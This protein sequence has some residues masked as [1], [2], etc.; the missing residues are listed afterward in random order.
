MQVRPFVTDIEVCG[1]AID[2]I[3][4]G[5]ALFPDLGLEKLAA[6]GIGEVHAADQ[7]NARPVVLIDRQRWYSQQ[8]WLDAF[9]DI[10]Q[11]MGGGLMFKIGF[12]VPKFAAFPERSSHQADNIVDGLQALDA[13]Y[14]MNHRKAGVVMHDAQSGV[15]LE[16]IGHYKM[17]SSEARRIVMCCENPYPC[18][19][20]RGLLHAV[21]TH[22]EPGSETVHDRGQGCRK[23]GGH[24]CTFD[25]TW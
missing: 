7:P 9:A 19:F 20:D 13:A 21:A 17:V 24:S 10:A 6:H 2:A 11:S 14:H 1:L 25:I 3:V 8:K 4:G 16:G 12:Q 15:M 22:F 5:F 23:S 18:D